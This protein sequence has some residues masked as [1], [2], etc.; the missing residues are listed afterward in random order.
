[1]FLGTQTH[2]GTIHLNT[3][4][5]TTTTTIMTRKSTQRTQT[6]ARPPS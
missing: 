3:T 1:V 2:D 4:I 6:S 5:T